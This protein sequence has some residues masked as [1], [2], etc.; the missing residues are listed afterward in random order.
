MR[1]APSSG[2]AVLRPGRAC[3]GIVQEHIPALGN[4]QA[5]ILNVIVCRRLESHRFQLCFHPAHYDVGEDKARNDGNGDPNK[6]KWL[7]G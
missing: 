3:D 2:I 5:V 1:A 6:G 7:L 4:I